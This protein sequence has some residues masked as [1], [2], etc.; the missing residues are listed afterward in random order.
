MYK[1]LE[2]CKNWSKIH[3]NGPKMQILNPK[4]QILTKV[5][6]KE[7]WKSRI[8]LP[9]SSLK[10]SNDSKIA[11]NI[12]LTPTCKFEEVNQKRQKIWKKKYPDY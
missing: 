9:G 1:N 5:I 7:V 4:M 2:T 12:N 6:F 10:W 3:Q 11:K 8:K